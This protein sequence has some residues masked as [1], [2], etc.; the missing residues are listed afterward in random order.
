MALLFCNIFKFYNID[1][2]DTPCNQ[3]HRYFEGVLVE[4]TKNLVG[5]VNGTLPEAPLDLL[6]PK[7]NAVII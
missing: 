2:Y 5:V 4:N 7:V 6:K 3:V 1:T